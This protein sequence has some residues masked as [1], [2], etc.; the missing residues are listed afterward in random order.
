[1]ERFS[2]DDG[3]YLEWA[4][5]ERLVREDLD[6]I[7][8]LRKQGTK[9]RRNMDKL[10]L[11]IEQRPGEIHLNFDEIEKRLDE[12]L[13]EY[14]GAVFTEESKSIASLGIFTKLHLYVLR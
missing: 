4:D 11:Q 10:R 1:M 8:E 5:Q 9:R 2:W 13:V 7:Q 6:R 12:R 14:K 3:N